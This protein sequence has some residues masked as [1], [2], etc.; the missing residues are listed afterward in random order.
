MQY[1]DNRK[2]NKKLTT[3][4]SGT[5][6]TQTLYTHY[7]ITNYFI[8]YDIRVTVNN[9]SNLSNQHLI[10]STKTHQY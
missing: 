1:C 3:W 5:G 6:I 2:K 8:F 10:L 7:Y 9:Y 4:Y